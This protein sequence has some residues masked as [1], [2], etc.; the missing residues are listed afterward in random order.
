MA[1]KCTDLFKECSHRVNDGC[2]VDR[3][4]TLLCHQHPNGV[5][6][7]TDAVSAQGPV[8]AVC[9]NNILT[10]GLRGHRN[11]CYAVGDV[12]FTSDG[13][14]SIWQPK[15]AGSRVHYGSSENTRP[16]KVRKSGVE[17][18]ED[19]AGV[20]ES[21]WKYSNRCRVETCGYHDGHSGCLISPAGIQ[22]DSKEQCQCR[23]YSEKPTGVYTKA[24]FVEIEWPKSHGPA[25]M[26]ID[27]MKL[28]FEGLGGS[29]DLVTTKITEVED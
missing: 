15:D 9:R 11:Q 4:V 5:S 2:S 14:C 7:S 16:W 25:W 17:P 24:F 29:N 26:N 19:A 10:C 21:G 28:W 20:P 23:L 13:T 3:G 27:N 18:K 1:R 8:V 6:K 22:V 12:T